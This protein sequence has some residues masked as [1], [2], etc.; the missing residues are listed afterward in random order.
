[1]SLPQH[2]SRNGDSIQ[3]RTSGAKRKRTAQDSIEE[4][5]AWTAVRCQ[6]LL[7][8]INSRIS[9]L[10]SLLETDAA[11]QAGIGGNNGQIR[12]PPK[13]TEHWSSVDPAWLPNGNP[14]GQGRTYVAKTKQADRK[15]L[16]ARDPNLAFPSPFVKR[17]GSSVYS[18]DDTSPSRPQIQPEK[19]CRRSRQLP[20][21]PQSAQHE[22]EN[23]LV[24][25]ISGL[26]GTTK[27]VAQVRM[28]SRSLLSTCLR[29]VPSHID[30][31]VEEDESGSSQEE[32]VTE[33]FT[34]LEDFGTTGGWPGLREVARRQGIHLVAKAISDNVLSEN[35]IRAMVDVCSSEGAM[36]EGQDL[37]RAWLNR[38]DVP[39]KDSLERLDIL[40]SRRRCAG[41][42]FRTINELSQTHSSILVRYGS[43]V[44]FWKE[45]LS[46][47]TGEYGE[48]A[49]QCLISCLSTFGDL[50]SDGCLKAGIRS[51]MRDLAL[52]V[53]VMATA[54]LLAEE[55]TGKGLCNALLAVAAHTCLTA[56]NQTQQRR[57]RR[58]RLSE[59][60]TLF[61]LGSQ[62]FLGLDTQQQVACGIFNV[63]TL[64]ATL[65]LSHRPSDGPRRHSEWRMCQEDFASEITK[66][67]VT[68][69]NYIDTTITGKLLDESLHAIER[70]SPAA[71]L[72]KQVALE[73]TNVLRQ[74]D[75]GPLGLDLEDY[76]K[77]LNQSGER[78]SSI[79]TPHRGG[80]KGRFRW[81][82]GLCEWVTA[83]PFL[84]R[85]PSEEQTE[86]VPEARNDKG[87]STSS[88]ECSPDVLAI[89][90]PAK[91]RRVQ[92][93]SPLWERK[94]TKA[95]VVLP[96]QR[97]RIPNIKRYA[98]NIED[99]SG[100]E[101]CF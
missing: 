67:I 81:E 58:G 64:T 39:S 12:K 59:F 100:D 28:G 86:L 83:T 54:S 16:K 18:K 90:P 85:E 93:K 68:L 98:E 56:G 7:R 78:A 101:L 46:S 55:L 97:L 50:E 80:Q 15:V 92:V 37:L 31:I 89:S 60:E 66:G 51:H 25:A 70:A 95:M 41:F 10:R 5:I 30:L 43:T 73:T 9:S 35:S 72:L 69:E 88:N 77:R 13:K 47:L 82:E 3:S 61:L 6:R 26:L 19:K 99:D 27:A 75:D 52:K 65:D 21:K 17:I 36:S 48:E 23:G 96:S 20:I 40:S 53:T 87:D 22:T 32:I 11:F 71:S 4:D 29:Q 14:K 94:V 42:K 49:T 76:M 38:T 44:E 62:L 34:Y 33:V 63:D 1:M 74:S 84:G 91:R 57:S 24:A 45:L 79:Q 2:T 8:T